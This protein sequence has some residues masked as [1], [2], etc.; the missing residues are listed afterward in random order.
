MGDI[1]LRHIPDLS[2]MSDLVGNS[3]ESSFQIPAA[4][5]DG[6]LLLA[7]ETMGF[8][9]NNNDSLNT[10]IPPARRHFQ[11]PLTL[12]ELTP[13]SKTTRTSMKSSP[14]RRPVIATPYR[15]TVVSELSAALSQ[16]MSP[17][18]DQDPSSEIPPPH[19]YEDNLMAG[20]EDDFLAD[21]QR[22][23][24]RDSH[25]HSTFPSSSNTLLAVVSSSPG[26]S[27]APPQ[28]SQCQSSE[29]G[30]SL[31]SNAPPTKGQQ[32]HVQSE[33]DTACLSLAVPTTSGSVPEKHSKSDAASKKSN[34]K[35]L[36]KTNLGQKK[37]PGGDRAKRKRVCTMS[38]FMLKF[39]GCSLT[40]SR[41]AL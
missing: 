13:H 15:E 30:V 35:V 41:L 36:L 18:R 25:T 26:E 11:P 17:L 1:S 19:R 4:A 37:L 8:F 27:P 38:R 9:D 21:E 3:S 29:P 24:E 20:D 28:L 39:S 40:Y 12:A 6:D 7:D 10:P 16:E 31:Q 23:L 14:R 5:H 22:S 34:G 33:L 32:L 2:D